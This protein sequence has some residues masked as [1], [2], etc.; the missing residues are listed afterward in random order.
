MRTSY[1]T[2]PPLGM[3]YQIVP[4]NLTTVGCE[5]DDGLIL[6]HS[7]AETCEVCGAKEPSHG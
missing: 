5:T 1:S 4:E 3:R 6:T 7:E 2:E